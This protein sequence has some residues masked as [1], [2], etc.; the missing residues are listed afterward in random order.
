M[1]VPNSAVS[2]VA[3]PAIPNARNAT[4]LA[5]LY[6]LQQSQWWSRRQLEKLQLTQFS[7]LLSHACS[8]VPW[9]REKLPA[10]ADRDFQ[11]HS[12]HE[13]QQLPVLT[14][15]QVQDNLDTL[16]ATALPQDHMPLKE[17]RTSGSTGTPITYRSTKVTGLFANALRLRSDLWHNQDSVAVTA[18]IQAGHHQP[19]DG[20]DR[21]T[22]GQTPAVRNARSVF[23]NGPTVHFYSGREIGEQLEWLQKIDPVRLVTYPSNLAA[24]AREARVRGVKLPRL[25]YL[26]TQGEVVSAET[27]DICREAWGLKIVDIYSCRE[28]NIIALQCPEREHY[29]VQS[30]R[31]IVEVL[32]EQDRPCGPGETGRVV[33]TDLHNFIMPFIRYE[34]GDFAEVGETCSC[35]RQLPVLKQIL[36]RSRNMLALPGGGSAWPVFGSND[37]AVITPIRQLQGVQHSLTDIEIKVVPLR[38]IDPVTE[39]KLQAIAQAKFDGIRKGFKVRL[40]CVDNIPRSKNGK[41]EDFISLVSG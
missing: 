30:E 14:R 4:R 39:A 21:E 7:T 33:L 23:P 37:L 9:Y 13:L 17:G 18:S 8:H 1:L 35:G 20:G 19:G 22:Q 3:W 10:F 12:L 29:H 5:L 11:L 27:R 16:T 24:L 41:Y 31:V 38:D 28:M 6:Q 34:N 36:G 32:D 2:G 15:E 40:T 25:R 26:C